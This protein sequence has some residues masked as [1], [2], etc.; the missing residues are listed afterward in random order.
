MLIS[1]TAS[2][3]K[4][5]IGEQHLPDNKKIIKPAQDVGGRAGTPFA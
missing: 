1:T 4:V 3:G 5:I 2:F